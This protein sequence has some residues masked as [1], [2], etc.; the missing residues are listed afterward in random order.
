MIILQGVL[1]SLTNCTNQ[2]T[3]VNINNINDLLLYSNYPLFAV[4]MA[5]VFLLISLFRQ[6]RMS[7]LLYCADTKHPPYLL[8]LLTQA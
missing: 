2:L 6:T 5:F 3:Y 7:I 1:P 8:G 4:D